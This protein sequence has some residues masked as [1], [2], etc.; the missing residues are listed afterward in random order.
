VGTV[1]DELELKLICCKLRV[2]VSRFLICTILIHGIGFL[3]AAEPLLPPFGLKWGDSP[4]GLV[5]WALRSSLDQTVKAPASDPRLKVLLVSSPKGPLPGHEATT[6]EARFIDGRLFEVTLHYTYPGRESTFV[7]GRFAE[8][9]R[10]LAQRHGPLGLGAKTRKQPLE[11]VSSSSI[12]YQRE[13]A[14]GRILM[15]V[16]TE[17]V[18][19]KRGD[20]SARFSVVYHNGGIVESDAPPVIIRRSEIGSPQKP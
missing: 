13:P 18:D 12:A 7:R 14:A 1:A 11:G 3:Q 19:T 20:R 4:N 8:L 9:K 15:L 16:L 2:A 6:L 5:E 17:V 10:I